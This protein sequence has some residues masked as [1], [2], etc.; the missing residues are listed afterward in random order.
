[1]FLKSIAVTVLAASLASAAESPILALVPEEASSVVGFDV[2]KVL[3]SPYGRRLLQRMQSS[4]PKLKL[5][6]QLGIDPAK[7]LQNVII[8]S[9]TERGKSLILAS[10]RFDA[11]K[12][13]QGLAVDLL[14]GSSKKSI[15]DGIEMTINNDG[16]A[17]AVAE[18]GMLLMGNEAALRQALDR[19]RV[20]AKRA[21]TALLSKAESWLSGY[22]LWFAS[23]GPT[24]DFTGR[25]GER[26]TGGVLNA[27]L[28]KGFDRTYGGLRFTD[29]LE[30]GVETAAKTEKD[31]GTMVRAMK[32]LSVVSALTKG[33]GNNNPLG[34]LES[35]DIRSEGRVVFLKLSVPKAA[36]EALSPEEQANP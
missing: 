31:A 23:A 8:S 33:N 13:A 3:G 30:V 2:A 32:L 26:A 17:M 18:G 16:N 12:I 5:L 15:Y 22:D 28:L 11:K 25:V 27:E 19:R 34:F 35:L 20:K 24:N 4:N 36:F 6:F 7:D 1:M 29:A 9:G 21:P 14:A 10:G